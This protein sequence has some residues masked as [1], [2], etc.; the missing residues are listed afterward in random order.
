LGYVRFDLSVTTYRGK[1]LIMGEL[2]K[3]PELWEW[4]VRRMG[5][6]WSACLFT[7]D[8]D[9][10]VE[11]EGGSLKISTGVAPLEVIEAV[12]KAR[13]GEL[14]RYWRADEITTRREKLTTLLRGEPWFNCVG[15]SEEEG[16][17]VVNPLGEIPPSFEL[18]TEVDEM[19]VSK[20]ERVETIY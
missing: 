15:F 17:L 20:V 16:A 12:L 9:C 10:V 7:V 5:G 11:V 6:Y 1:K 13:A 4:R 8:V 18:L 2:P 19:P 3:L 14:R